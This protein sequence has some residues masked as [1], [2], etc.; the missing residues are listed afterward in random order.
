L[1]IPLADSPFTDVGRGYWFNNAVAFVFNEGI[2]QG[3]DT[4]TFAPNAP[5][6]RAMLVT[7]LHRLADEP[8]PT[9]SHGFGDVAAGQWYADAVAWAFESGIVLGVSDDRFAPG[10]PITREQFAT[11]LHRYAVFAGLD[12]TIPADV[13]IDGF[14]DAYRVSDWA[15]DAK[16]WAYYHGLITGRT[17]T[18]I[19]P[20]GTAIRA[21]A[22]A[23]LQR[24]VDAFLT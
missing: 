17:V 15:E 2:M 7:I 5:L 12:T 19:V 13:R 23:I 21:E 20:Y 24:F 16:L 11:M 3:T 18:A 14:V 4:T 9:A 22:A 1:I 8:A 6:S 10:D